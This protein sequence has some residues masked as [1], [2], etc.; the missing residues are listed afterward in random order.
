MA[1]EIQQNRNKAKQHQ[2]PRPKTDIQKSKN[3]AFGNYI[4]A[5]LEEMDRNCNQLQKS[6]N[7]NSPSHIIF[8]EIQN[9]PSKIIKEA[10]TSNFRT[11]QVIP[12]KQKEN[13]LDICKANNPDITKKRHRD[14]K[15][16]N[17]NS[18]RTGNVAKNDAEEV[19]ISSTTICATNKCQDYKTIKDSRTGKKK[20]D[21]E[22]SEMNIR[23]KHRN[24]QWHMKST[25][26]TD[27][28]SLTR[29]ENIIYSGNKVDHG[30]STQPFVPHTNDMPAVQKSNIMSDI[31][32]GH[33]TDYSD[34]GPSS[35]PSSP[36]QCIHKSVQQINTGS[37]VLP[38]HS[39]LH[40]ASLDTYSVST[41]NC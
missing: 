29:E 5:D 13:M 15:Q 33:S 3:V 18:Q 22:M 20:E 24:E 37:D 17:V 41:L 30:G 38:Q 21:N 28:S 25:L 14:T 35:T 27:L 34:Y 10:T 23:T 31:H 39:P 2:K 19:T 9:I 32:S 40:Y 6:Q 12:I 1:S 7:L 36:F 16:K 8:K 11:S 4:F 26:G